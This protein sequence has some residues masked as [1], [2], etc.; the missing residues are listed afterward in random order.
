MSDNRDSMLEMYI[1]E[2][3][4]LINNLEESVISIDKEENLREKIEE[5]FRIMHTIKGNSMMMM[6]QNVAESAHAV[7]DLFDYIRTKKPQSMD[8]IKIVDMLLGV[9]DFIKDEINKLKLTGNCD[10]DPSEIKS[11]I[12]KNL[13]SLKFLNKHEDF[14]GKELKAS[15]NQK[16]YIAPL[17]PKEEGEF[18]K[19]HIN[20]KFEEDCQ[21]ENIRAFTIVH[22]LKE[23]F[24]NL[25]FEPS[26]IV[27]D[28]DTA[29]I[30]KDKGFDLY[31]DCEKSTEEIKNLFES[32]SFIENLTIEKQNLIENNSKKEEKIENLQNKAIEINKDGYSEEKLTIDKSRNKPITTVEHINVGLDKVDKLMDLIGELVVSEAM[33]TR[34][35]DLIG[36]ELENFSKSSRQLR[37]VIR[38]IQDV[39]MTLRMLP[40]SL[41]FQKMQRIVRDM[42]QKI[43]KEVELEIIGKE[44]TV[45]KKIIE[46]LSDPLM[47]IIRNSMDHGI[48][49]V[50]DR[51]KKEKTEKGKIIL[52]ARHSS[53]DVVISVKDDGAG[54]SKEK[55][56]K[57]AKERGLLSKD[58]KEYEESEIYS[59]LFK[60]G[61][62][63]KE[64]VT[65]FSGRG[66]GL[67]VVAKNIQSIGGNITIKSEEGKGS[68]FI[69]RIPL[70]LSIID[71]MILKTGNSIF[72][73]PIT[74][75][76]ESFA[77]KEVT[78]IRDPQGEEVILIRG[79]CYP[80]FRL[81]EKYFVDTKVKEVEKGILVM[82][83]SEGKFKM[84]F[85]DELVGEQQVVVKK[86]PEYLR[87]VE[88]ISGC[89]LMGDG[90]ISLILDPQEIIRL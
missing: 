48:E 58:E 45:D 31:F 61:F 71:G 62:S 59:F 57:K 52:S 30:I 8:F 11:V 41:T 6:I 9:I 83:E 76:K 81:H 42:N 77:G 90:K 2:T 53:G 38:E 25:K 29:E 80:I 34:N 87:K 78:F 7:E 13:E 63:T 86:L 50:E 23:Q 49:S 88:G 14:K 12:N 69:I 54:I 68:E 82:I 56:L 79:E 22:N 46:A 3:Q 55:I 67:D 28:P 21:M 18:N 64:S 84:I 65:E 35:P 20:I 15:E 5:V 47:H 1:V 73:I 27:E 85:A 60:S 51:I 75:I 89:T 19:F 74:A 32:I 33:V 24:K 17:K 37:M 70:T 10:G 16:Y 26:N 44:T 66:V 40:L 43:G 72:T 39:V 4:E 36:M